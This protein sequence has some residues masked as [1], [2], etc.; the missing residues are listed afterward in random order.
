STGPP[1]AA[2]ST[3]SRTSRPR[4][5]SSSSATCSACRPAS[6]GPFAA[7]RWRSLGAL[8]PAPGLERLRAGNRAGPPVTPPGVRTADCGGIAVE[9]RR[10]RAGSIVQIGVVIVPPDGTGDINNYTL[11]YYT[12]DARLANGLQR[13]GVD[14]QQVPTLDYA[15][16]LGPAGT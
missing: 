12:S 3:W 16:D 10:P 5:R 7:G 4:C 6:A 13:L 11:W 1:R 14:A 8:E 9:G 2:A 15:F